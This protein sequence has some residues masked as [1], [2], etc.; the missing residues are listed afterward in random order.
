MSC[1]AWSLT[2]RLFGT[3]HQGEAGVGC[4]SPK[5]VYLRIGRMLPNQPSYFLPVRGLIYDP[6]SWQPLY[7]YIV[8]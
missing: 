3:L 8:P 7:R 1:S 2:L 4:F 6:A 5:W